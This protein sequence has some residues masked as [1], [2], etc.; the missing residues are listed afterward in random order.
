MS[1]REYRNVL[2]ERLPSQADR[3]VA[4]PAAYDERLP[5]ARNSNGFGIDAETVDRA[6]NLD[7]T[8]SEPAI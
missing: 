5:V 8:D 7:V 4:S 2:D 1:A 6:A 3:L